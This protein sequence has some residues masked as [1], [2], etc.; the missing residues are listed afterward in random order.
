LTLVLKPSASVSGLSGQPYA[1]DAA[2]WRMRW[3]FYDRS[4]SLPCSLYFSASFF[5]A[6]AAWCHRMLSVCPVWRRYTLTIY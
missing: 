5:I 3:T 1:Y 2:D 6:W 4:Q